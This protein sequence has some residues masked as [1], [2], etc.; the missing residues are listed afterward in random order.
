MARTS[1]LSPR[2]SPRQARSIETRRVILEGAARVLREEG[3]AGFNTNRV[4]QVAG[5]SVGSLYQYYPN[6]GAVLFQLDLLDSVESWS[7]IRAILADEELTTRE[8][9][10]AGVHAFFESEA[11]ESEL[12]AQLRRAESYYER[13]PEY[14]GR[15]RRAIRDVRDFLAKALPEAR[16]LDFKAGFFTTVVASVAERVTDRGANPRELRRW[17]TSCSEMLCDHLGIE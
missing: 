17:S 1:S 12:R 16:E 3:P 6:K 11:A 8:R 7:R 9:V 5:V 10:F 14:E 13:K 4:A 15:N 2:K